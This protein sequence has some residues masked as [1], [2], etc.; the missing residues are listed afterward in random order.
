MSV[1][2]KK[3]WIIPDCELPP[4]GEGILKGHESVIVVNDSDKTAHIAVKLFFRMKKA[5]ELSDIAELDEG[6]MHRLL[7][8]ALECGEESLL[9]SMRTKRYTDARIRR[10]ML[11]AMLGV[12]T[13]D[14]KSSPAYTEL[15]GANE[16][17][18]S[19]L[20]KK[21]KAVGLPIIAKPSDIPNTEGAK[22]QREL[23]LLLDSVFSL[24]LEKPTSLS[25]VAARSPIII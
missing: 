20:S 3:E 9:D 19:L 8:G 24:A 5:E 16:V 7:N 15:L 14:I 1:C 11:F 22:R 10:A 6:L 18:R 2:G 12:K 25:R 4:E 21:R 13:A 17:G 23:S